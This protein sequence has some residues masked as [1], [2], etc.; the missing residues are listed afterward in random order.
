MWDTVV[1][2]GCAL[3]SRFHP[4]DVINVF[5]ADNFREL[6]VLETTVPGNHHPAFPL[7]STNVAGADP[8]RSCDKSSQFDLAVALGKMLP[9]LVMR[10]ELVANGTGRGLS[11]I[12]S[13]L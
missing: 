8:V 12:T 13:T 11:A 9:L 4:G 7:L 6:V 1:K 5:G 3:P 2:G 10:N